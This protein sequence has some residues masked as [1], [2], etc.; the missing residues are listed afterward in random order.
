MQLPMSILVVD[1]EIDLGLILK[2]FL[3]GFGFNVV[4]FTNSLLA[5]EH[6]KHN[7]KNYSLIITDLRMPGISGIDLANKI[8]KE[9]SSSIKIFLITAFDISD[10]KDQSNFNSAKIERVIQK[11]IKLSHLKKMINQTFQQQFSNIENE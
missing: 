10:L 1:D 11:P 2:Q 4:S 6:L 7:H 3:Q 5:F 8:R 9:V